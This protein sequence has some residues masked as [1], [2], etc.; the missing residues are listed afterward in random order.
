M[1]VKTVAEFKAAIETPSTKFQ[2][3]DFWAEWCVPCKRIAPVLDAIE[4]SGVATVLKVNT[5]TLS[6]EEL[7]T[8]YNVRTIPTLILINTETK[9]VGTH[10]GTITEMELRAKLKNL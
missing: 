4:A 3:I 10:F 7:L 2:I 1:E 6:L 9:A 8:K 5:E